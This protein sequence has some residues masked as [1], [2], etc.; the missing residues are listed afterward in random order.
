MINKEVVCEIFTR[1]LRARILNKFYVKSIIFLVLFIIYIH[2]P[3][4]NK[5]RHKI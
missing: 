2:L 3:F 1:F 5:Y 4:V